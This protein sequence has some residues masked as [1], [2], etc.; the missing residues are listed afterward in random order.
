[1]LENGPGAGSWHRA[2]GKDDLGLMLME[3][4]TFF[5]GTFHQDGRCVYADDRVAIGL[6]HE[7]GTAPI[8]TGSTPRGLHPPSSPGR[9]SGPGLER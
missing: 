7:T 2:R 5:G 8:A 4:A 6:V 9:A 1:M 3:L